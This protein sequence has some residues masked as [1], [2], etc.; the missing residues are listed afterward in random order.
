MLLPAASRQSRQLKRWLVGKDGFA[1]AQPET[2][3][4]IYEALAGDRFAGVQEV[5]GSPPTEVDIAGDNAKTMNNTITQSDMFVPSTTEGC[6]LACAQCF[7]LSAAPCLV[8]VLMY[9]RGSNG[10]GTKINSSS[11]LCGVIKS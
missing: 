9:S 4:A 2:S 1:L 8:F 5:L 7:C 10:R 11:T 3:K 6:C